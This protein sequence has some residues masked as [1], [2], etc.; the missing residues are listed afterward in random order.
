LAQAELIGEALMAGALAALLAAGL[1]GLA[2]ALMCC[3][4][5]VF[6]G[7][8]SFMVVFVLLMGEDPRLPVSFKFG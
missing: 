5:S 1:V 3:A 7:V 4:V 2:E 6:V 8:V